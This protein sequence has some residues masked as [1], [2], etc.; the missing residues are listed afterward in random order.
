MVR[1][2]VPPF[3]FPP[4]T[5][6]DE[7]TASKRV[8]GQPLVENIWGMAQPLPPSPSLVHP[9]HIHTGHSNELTASGTSAAQGGGHEG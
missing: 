4:D 7:L 2:P 5:H 9:L 6:S 8:S 1:G 3:P